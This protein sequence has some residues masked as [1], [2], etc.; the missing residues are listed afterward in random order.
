MNPVCPKYIFRKSEY[1]ENRCSNFRVFTV[2]GREMSLFFYINF[3]KR[4]QDIVFNEL[5]KNSYI[6]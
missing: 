1:F 4:K 5:V 3:N 6:S 2:D